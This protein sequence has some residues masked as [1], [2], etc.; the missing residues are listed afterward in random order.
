[1]PS[2]PDQISALARQHSA[3][4]RR[5][6]ARALGDLALALDRADAALEAQLSTLTPGSLAAQRALWAQLAGRAAR[7]ASE[8]ALRATLGDWLVKYGLAAPGHADEEI[9]AWLDYHGSTSRPLNLGAI[10]SIEKETLLQRSETSIARYGQEV[11]RSVQVALSL[12]PTT[13]ATLEETTARVMGA[14]QA[15]RWQAERIARTEL[16]HAYNAS[17]LD[18]LRAARTVIP[19]LKKTCIVTLDSR[20]ALDSRKLIAQVRELEDYF[21]DGAGR[22]YLHPPG[23]PND[24]E[25]EVA[26]ID[27]DDA[28]EVQLDE[29][30]ALEE[31]QRGAAEAQAP[32]LETPAGR[33]RRLA[34]GWTAGSNGRVAL[35]LKQAALEEF[36]LPG[37]LYSKQPVE[38]DAGDVVQ[39]REDVA[40][41]YDSTQRDFAEK[42]I[43]SVRL[44]R[45]VRSAT[46]V[47][48][49]LESW[50]TNEDE[51]AAFGDFGVMVQDVPIDRIL[52]SH[53]S[54]D[55]ATSKA[56]RSE[57]LVM[58]ASPKPRWLDRD[59]EI[60]FYNAS[61]LGSPEIDAR[62][63]WGIAGEGSDQT[64]FHVPS[65]RTVLASAS[66][67]DLRELARQLTSSGHVDGAGRL[68][69]W[70]DE[71][72]LR[73]QALDL[74]SKADTR[75]YARSPEGRAA[76]RWRQTEFDLGGLSSRDLD[77]AAE[78]AGAFGV[79][80]YGASDDAPA[81]SA[82]VELKTGRALL[83]G[84]YTKRDL[85]ELAASIEALVDEKGRLP[86]EGDPAYGALVEELESARAYYQRNRVDGYPALS[87]EVSRWVDLGGRVDFPALNDEVIV[88]KSGTWSRRIVK[89]LEETTSGDFNVSEQKA[90][91]SGNFAIY[92]TNSTYQAAN[93]YKSSDWHIVHTRTGVKLHSGTA[94]KVSGR[95]TADSP[96]AIG[97]WTLGEFQKVASKLEKYLDAD[98]SV[99]P[100]F[101]EDWLADVEFL[102]R[103]TA[104]G[105]DVAVALGPRYDRED[106]MLSPIS[107]RVRSRLVEEA[108]ALASDDAFDFLSDGPFAD[109]IEDAERIEDVPF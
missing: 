96:F 62:G 9:G 27:E 25:K 8:D 52:W 67:D 72:A 64:L 65:G 92:S 89:V 7:G 83:H 34:R 97:G 80:E 24:R 35:T 43:R 21:E 94:M 20:T 42:G 60:G 13:Q 102:Q 107:R 98:G 49:V 32:E 47:Q 63:V 56:P 46:D 105:E 41:I 19:G 37:A 45:G 108:D 71:D 93:G 86:G 68:P 40:R 84:A 106:W 3:Q 77:P 15:Q 74:V 81:G 75:R 5:F 79:L 99:L 22:R 57:Y 91:S 50:T 12:A 29:E 109:E 33:A 36:G 11:A 58:P 48:G 17:H 1:M 44:Y 4:L 2:V 103:Q 70:R 6:E 73:A 100:G 78:R 104:P 76:L 16:A 38:L 54:P 69:D 10:V 59:F 28:N 55:W 26:W 18:S 53:E 30:A 23:R 51:A 88:G 101:E 14:A 66:R 95:S 82:L 85:K 61:T 87:G 31:Q 90:Y 39:A